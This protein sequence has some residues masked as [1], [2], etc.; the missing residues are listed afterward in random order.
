[1][2]EPDYT[3]LKSQFVAL[4]GSETD[5]AGIELLCNAYCELQSGNNNLI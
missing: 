2:T 5:Q 3:L 1:M 4:V